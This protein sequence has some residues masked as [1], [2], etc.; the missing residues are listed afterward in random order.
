MSEAMSAIHKLRY[1]FMK[2]VGAPVLMGLSESLRKRRR[3]QAGQQAFGPPLECAERLKEIITRHYLL[4][5]YAAGAKPVAWVTSGA[6]AELLRV[7]DYYTVY[8]ENHGAL[9]GARKMGPQL[10][11]VAEE[12]GYHQDLCSYARIDLGHYFS[13][14][15]PVGRLPKPDLMFASNNICFFITWNFF[16][17]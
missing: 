1:Y 3:P 16:S 7:F 4:A 2:D 12:H 9:C 13:R 14:N 10:C 11:S 17:F 5:R 15:T 8:P 6:P